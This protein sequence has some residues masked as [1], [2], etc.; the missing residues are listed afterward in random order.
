MVANGTLGMWEVGVPAHSAV[1]CTACGDAIKPDELRFTWC[2]FDAEVKSLQPPADF[3]AACAVREGSCG[4]HAKVHRATVRRSLALNRK[5]GDELDAIL[6]AFT[7]P[8]VLPPESPKQPQQQRRHVAAPRAPNV[9]V[10]P[11]KRP[12]AAAS[13]AACGARCPKSAVRTSLHRRRSVATRRDGTVERAVLQVRRQELCAR[14]PKISAVQAA[15]GVVGATT[16]RRAGP[17]RGPV[18]RRTETRER[19]VS[20]SKDGATVIKETFTICRVTRR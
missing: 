3:H 11:L 4:S 6:S 17:I 12:A 10:L 19:R 18:Q 5:L 9:A 16:H 1:P 2:P 15:R 8:D 20:T 7:P 13:S 14:A